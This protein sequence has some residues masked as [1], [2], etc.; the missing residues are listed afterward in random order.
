MML[1]EN[2]IY[3]MRKIRKILLY[4]SLC[5]V[6]TSF[7]FVHVSHAAFLSH[8]EIQ[9]R[10]KQI[11][12]Q[13]KLLSERLADIS[14]PQAKTALRYFFSDLRYGMRQNNDVKLLQEFLISRGYLA[15]D[16]ATG[17][18]FSLT[19]AAVQKFQEDNR[20]CAAGF[21]GPIT[22]ARAN[23]I[24]ESDFLSAYV[25]LPKPGY[26]LTSIA[27]LIHGAVNAQ[28]A[29]S[30]NLPLLV[31]DDA[32]A[33]VARAH[34]EDQARDNIALTN[35][36][37]LCAY[38][39]IRHEGLVFG[40]TVGDRLTNSNVPFRVA[41]ENI[42]VFPVS[43][44]L[45]YVSDSPMEACRRI[46][47]NTYSSPAANLLEAQV[48]VAQEIQK[49]LSLIVKEKSVR[50]VNR[51]WL[52]EAQIAE[53]AVRDWMSSEGHRKNI[54]HAAFTKTGVGIVG[55]GDYILITQVFVGKQ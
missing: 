21:F 9:A 43:K 25:I 52:T 30:A 2:S 35:P 16:M 39:F 49:R 14:R 40:L 34:S 7:L 46:D 47:L 22:R 41:G 6:L 36:D 1:F 50:W 17:N 53:N 4:L 42:I 27:K 51:E 28:R 33:N 20:I 32:L 23:S 18:F 13:I 11:S 45:V 15:P 3:H 55:V 31:W 12:D 54:I 48:R 10:I 5:A 26:N 44:N 19:R 38:P 29:A 24:L 8:A 37:L